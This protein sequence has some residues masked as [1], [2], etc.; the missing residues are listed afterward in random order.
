MLRFDVLQDAGTPSKF[1]LYE[2][3]ES[4][5]AAAAH[6][7]TAHYRKWRDTVSDWMVKPRKGEPASDRRSKGP[8]S[9]VGALLSGPLP[10]IIFGAGKAKYIPAM[11]SEYGAN[12]LLLTGK[13][14]FCSRNTGTG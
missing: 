7:E 12:V 14:H 3:Y 6:K 4:S 10:K 1:V 9:M 11:V 8:G 5:E 2:A 13:I